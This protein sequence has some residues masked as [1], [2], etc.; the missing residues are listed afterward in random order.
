MEV[1]YGKSNGCNSVPLVFTWWTRSHGS[2]I[3]LGMGWDLKLGFEMCK[4]PNTGQLDHVKEKMQSNEDIGPSFMKFM[5]GDSH[6]YGMTEIEMA[7]L[8]GALF[9]G[10]TQLYAQCSWLLHVP[11]RSKLKFRLHLIWSSEGTEV[12]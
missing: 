2:N 11:P 12:A 3:F 10:G 9:G 4:K 1:A 8:A 7:F 5:L 6:V